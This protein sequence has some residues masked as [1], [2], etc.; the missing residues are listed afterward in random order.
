MAPGLANLNSDLRHWTMP[1]LPPLHQRRHRP[2]HLAMVL[3]QF[4][5][6]YR[7]GVPGTP[8]M[9]LP[10]DVE[11]FSVH[12]GFDSKNKKHAGRHFFVEIERPACRSDE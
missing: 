11:P 1:R 8:E 5:V 6:S 9:S 3:A 4:D 10:G 2:T 7:T 12:W